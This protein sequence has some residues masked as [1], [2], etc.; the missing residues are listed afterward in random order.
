MA[1][2]R[3]TFREKVRT[4]VLSGVR[5]LALAQLWFD[6]GLTFVK[7]SDRD[8]VWNRRARQTQEQDGTK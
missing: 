1:D 2:F 6:Y 7:L 3:S 8:W 5:L 4:T